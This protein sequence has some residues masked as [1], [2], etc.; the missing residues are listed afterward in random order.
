VVIRV[1]LVVFK[2]RG[3]LE[4]K[5]KSG[6]VVE[7]DGSTCNSYPNLKMSVAKSKNSIVAT[8]GNKAEVLL[9]SQPNIKVALERHFGKPIKHITQI[10]GRKKA[11]NLIEFED[12]T[13]VPVQN[14]NGP[15]DGRGHSVDRRKVSLLTGDTGLH[16]LL[17]RVCLKKESTATAPATAVDI[18]KTI[19]ELCGSLCLLGSDEVNKPQYFLHTTM[20]AEATRILTLSIV[21]SDTFMARVK[22]DMFPVME[23]KKTCVHLSPNLYFQ[24]KGG[25]ATDHSPDDI[26]TKLR[27]SPK[28]SKAIPHPTDLFSLFTEL[29]LV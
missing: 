20:D 2:F 3:V 14:K 7:D 1:G 10:S 24:R 9:C 28:P 18:P 23:T 15:C 6:G 19:S 12:G 29:P 22:A 4:I 17:E 13:T 11:D 21:T 25:G 8:T 26:Q 16:S 27:F 5:L